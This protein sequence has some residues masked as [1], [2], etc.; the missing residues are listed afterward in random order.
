MFDLMAPIRRCRPMAPLIAVVVGCLAALPASAQFSPLM[1]SS[2]MRG[3]APSASDMAQEY[4]EK[5]EFDSALQYYR[6]AVMEAL[7]LPAPLRDVRLRFALPRLGRLLTAH[8]DLDEAERVL[9]QALMLAD[10]TASGSSADAVRALG[11]LRNAMQMARGAARAMNHRLW[12]EGEF[13]EEVEARLAYSLPQTDAA[14]V[15]LAEVMARKG[16]ADRVLRLWQREM[17]LWLERAEK[18]PEGLRVLKAIEVEAATWRM[19]LALQAVGALPEAAESIRLAL[20]WNR[21]RLAAVAAKSAGTDGLLEGI[22][23]RRWMAA[24]AVLVAAQSAQPEQLRQAVGAIT[25]S[26][27]LL[28]RYTQRRRHLLAQMDERAVRRAR[29]DLAVLEARLD[30]LPTDGEEGVRAWGEWSNDQ[31]KALQPAMPALARG[32]LMDV[33]GDGEPMLARI[34]AR[35]GPEEAL[36]G[37][38]AVQQPPRPGEV[39][40]V[41]RYW[42]YTV[43]AQGVSLR[44][45]GAVAALNRMVTRWRSQV[46]GP[47]A[48]QAGTTLAELL[49]ADLPA[50]VRAAPRWIV[51][52]DGLLGLLP[53]EALPD[54]QGAATLLDQHAIRYV[55]SLAQLADAGEPV[56]L[57]RSPALVVADPQYPAVAAAASTANVLAMRSATGQTL[58]DMVFQ[59]LPETR[60]EG[61]QV[62]RV[63]QGMGIEARLLTG[64]Q[65]TPQRLREAA[66]PA[67]LHV[68]S[69][70]VLLSPAPEGNA[71]ASQRVRVVLPGQLAGLVLTGEGAGMLL[72]GSDL[73]AMNLRG[74][75]LVVLSACDTGNGTIDVHEGLTSLRRAAE[76]AGAQ[77]TLTS[78]W[79]V[80]SQAT[81]ALMGRFYGELAGGAPP[82]KALQTAKLAVRQAGASTRDW[83]GFVLAGTDR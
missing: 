82:S 73:A 6:V 72:T 33:I 55:T 24:S 22:M 36:I 2:V 76:E 68:A 42:R 62:S 37:F 13:S 44:N 70:G 58:R 25:S 3:S 16:N 61:E 45:V 19:A 4:E 40:T 5:G 29:A 48:R 57:S 43:T 64:A 35:L 9:E 74:T 30:S 10:Y 65:A 1:F 47:A 79:P 83:A 28:G 26:K 54:S 12:L 77:S 46:D 7:A 69:H 34:Q 60:A 11:A 67:V 23:Q 81:V 80:P 71:T 38:V 20:H 17:R 31:F 63:L 32:G 8:G 56:P 52:P 15:L 49:L 75:R 53:F 66:A 41:P 21:Q 59:P 78:L 39:V 27:G 14:S 51:D 18:E 50:E